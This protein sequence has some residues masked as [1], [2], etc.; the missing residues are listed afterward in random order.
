MP[1]GDRAPPRDAPPVA[2]PA[3]CGDRCL[4]PPR[5]RRPC[6][7]RCPARGCSA[8]L[9]A[10]AQIQNVGSS[11]LLVGADA[12]VGALVT[13]WP[14]RRSAGAP[15]RG[16]ATATRRGRVP[17]LVAKA[18]SG[19]ATPRRRARPHPS[20]PPPRDADQIRPRHTPTASNCIGTS[21]RI[22]S[23][24]SR[25]RIR[26]ADCPVTLAASPVVTSSPSNDAAPSIR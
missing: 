17:S 6:G 21:T 26:S 3:G 7:W 19:L 22:T 1:D 12:L 11:A 25:A 4:A 2:E 8:N 24:C 20:R 14:S 13:S 15:T 10:L 23:L 9:T 16:A 5:T 18:A